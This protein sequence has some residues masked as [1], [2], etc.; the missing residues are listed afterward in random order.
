MKGDCMCYLQEA[1]TNFNFKVVLHLC[2]WRERGR[3]VWHCTLGGFTVRQKV[4]L[5][6]CCPMCFICHQHQISQRSG[7]PISGCRTYEPKKLIPGPRNW[8]ASWLHF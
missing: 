5:R 2:T 3:L 8:T 6:N 4:S 1:L 7:T